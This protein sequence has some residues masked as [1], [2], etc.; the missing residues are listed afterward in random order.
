MNESLGAPE[1]RNGSIFILQTYS[2]SDLTGEGSYTFGI[3]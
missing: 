2:T 3:V 1:R